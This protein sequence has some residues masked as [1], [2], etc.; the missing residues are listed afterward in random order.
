VIQLEAILKRK[1]VQFNT[2]EA[3][4]ARLK[5]KE[6]ALQSCI[7]GIEGSVAATRAMLEVEADAENIHSSAGPCS[8]G[9]TAAS[10]STIVCGSSSR[11]AG[12]R[13]S[14]YMLSTTAQVSA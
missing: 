5:Q 13:Q 11:S 1:L 6:W 4:N 10:Y 7:L 8:S 12:W 3:E 9:D 14:G 2:L